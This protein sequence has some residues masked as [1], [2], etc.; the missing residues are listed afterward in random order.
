MATSGL[1]TARW[2]VMSPL[3]PESGSVALTVRMTLP[4]GVCSGSSTWKRRKPQSSSGSPL[5]RAPSIAGRGGLG[6]TRQPKPR[7]SSLSLA[8]ETTGKGPVLL[9]PSSIPG[10]PQPLARAPV[11][12]NTLPKPAFNRNLPRSHHKHLSGLRPISR[13]LWPTH[14]AHPFLLDSL[15]PA[16]P[17]AGACLRVTCLVS[18][19]SMPQ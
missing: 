5:P 13:L 19:P 18:T 6:L 2:K 7:S 3:L 12:Q 8:R 11:P 15:H 1:G 17:L 9:D 14:C 4:A 16:V 10:A